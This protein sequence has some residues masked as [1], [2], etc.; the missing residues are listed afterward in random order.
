ME[1][2]K[3]TGPKDIVALTALV[4]IVIMKL[5]GASGDLDAL[6]AL[7]IGYYFAHRTCGTDQGI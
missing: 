7:I 5:Q 4:L 3:L 6:L 1:K 2:I